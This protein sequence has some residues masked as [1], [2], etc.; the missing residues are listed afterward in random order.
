M[1]RNETKSI[2]LLHLLKALTLGGN[3]V[4]IAFTVLLTFL[5]ATFERKRKK[6]KK[7]SKKGHEAFRLTEDG[8]YYQAI[9]TEA[10]PE[11]IE[12]IEIIK[13]LDR[14]VEDEKEGRNKVKEIRI[15]YGLIDGDLDIRD[16]EKLE[17]F[18]KDG[19]EYIRIP[20]VELIFRDTI[21]DGNVNFIFAQFC[22]RADFRYAQFCGRADFRY[23][24]FC[25]RADFRSAQFKKETY[26]VSAQFSYLTDFSSAQFD[27]LTD[28]RSAQ[29]SSPSDFRSVQFCD[30]TYFLYAQFDDLTDFS[31]AQFSK[32]T[33]FRFAQFRFP[34]LFAD[35]K[36]W[37]DSL[38]VT[39][40]RLFWKDGIWSK[41]L[42]RV[43]LLPKNSPEGKPQEPVQFYIENS[44]IDEFSNPSF[45]RYVADQQY[46]REFREIHRPL[47][48][49]WHIIS[50]C[51]RSINLWAFWSV[52]IAVTFGLIYRFVFNECFVFTSEA[53]GQKPRWYDFIYYSIVT[54]ATL[55]FGDIAPSNPWARTVVALEAVLGYIMLGGLISILVNKLARRI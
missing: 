44:K 27:D 23:A 50:N 46:I 20:N 7:L 12:A 45:K 25:G 22:G 40:A 3:I 9:G 11:R 4:R 31:Y 14:I 49:F 36:Y 28:F 5:L 26:F 35:V 55:G 19:N 13:A 38:K 48:W 54:F 42:K 34:T 52:L 6:K 1:L 18:E 29:F 30:I 10:N 41:I 33:D 15:S 39:V 32:L 53:L 17:R 24:Q 37:S 47:Y 51:G 16:A 21:F 43:L 8:Q 2:N